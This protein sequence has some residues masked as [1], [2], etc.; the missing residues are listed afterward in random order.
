MILDLCLYYYVLLREAIENHEQRYLIKDFQTSHIQKESLFGVNHV[1]VSTSLCSGGVLVEGC[2]DRWP[3]PYFFVMYLSLPLSFV[4]SL[5]LVFSSLCPCSYGCLTVILDSNTCRGNGWFFLLRSDACGDARRYPDPTPSFHNSRRRRFRGSSRQHWCENR[6]PRGGKQILDGKKK[7]SW[8]FRIWYIRRQVHAGRLCSRKNC[9]DSVKRWGTLK[10]HTCA[11]HDHTV[12]SVFRPS[13]DIAG[14]K[15]QNW[16]VGCDTVEV[17]TRGSSHDQPRFDLALVV[18]FRLC[19]SGD[20]VQRWRFAGGPS[21]RADR[22]ASQW[23]SWSK[24]SKVMKHPSDIL[25]AQV[26]WTTDVGCWLSV[27]DLCGKAHVSPSAMSAQT[28][29]SCIDQ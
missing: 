6:K 20:R 26:V 21:D 10:S 24:L 13:H 5:S 29:Y 22:C 28:S 8:I 17:S 16:C 1:L 2:V 9:R 12:Y 14:F 3:R 23:Q 25:V 18:H 19:G 4:C 11:M 27:I 7:E 15:D